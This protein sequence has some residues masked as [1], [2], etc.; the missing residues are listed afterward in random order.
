MND[1]PIPES[2][3]VTD[4]EDEPP[5]DPRK[6]WDN[7]DLPHLKS[8]KIFTTPR[9]Y[10]YELDPLTNMFLIGSVVL[11]VPLC[12]TMIWAIGLAIWRTIFGWP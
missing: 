3:R 9:E 4:D 6:H 8:P 1:E 5:T 10:R 12:G 2:T 7:I 11:F